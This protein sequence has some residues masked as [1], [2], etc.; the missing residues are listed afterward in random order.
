MVT[1][2]K[3]TIRTYVLWALLAASALQSVFATPA[4]VRVNPAVI[5]MDE[6][7]TLTISLDS[8]TLDSPDLSVLKDSFQVLKKTNASSLHSEKGVTLIRKNWVLTLL[9]KKKGS[10]IIPSIK[11]G[12]ESTAPIRLRVTDKIVSNP[13]D[14]TEV[15]ST[16]P[17]K[18]DGDDDTDNKGS[19]NGKNVFVEVETDIQ[20][21]DVKGYVQGQ[22]VLTQKIYH[23]I[24]LK[25]ATLSPPVIKNN[26]AE[27]IPLPQEA[28][29]YWRVKGK[30]YHVIERSY[31]LFPKYSGTLEIEKADFSGQAESPKEESNLAAFGLSTGSTKIYDVK[32]SA[33]MLSLDINAQAESYS[34]E[35]WLPAKNI[36]LYRNWS[37]SLDNL[38]I[39]QPVTV[40]LGIIADGLRA[41]QLPDIK[42]EIP[43]DVKAYFQPVELNN[44]LTLAGVTGVWSQKITLIPSKAKQIDIPQFQLS[45]WNTITEQQETG[46]LEEQTL[47]VGDSISNEKEE[48]GR[49]SD[50]KPKQR[51]EST[52]FGKILLLFLFLSLSGYLFY[53]FRIRKAPATQLSK[54]TK[55]NKEDEKQFLLDALKFACLENDPQKVHQLLPQWA[56]EIAGIKPSTL[57][58]IGKANQGYMQHEIEQ[59]SRALY[60]KSAPNW[61]GVGLW[62]VINKYSYSDVIQEKSVRLKKMYP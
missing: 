33:P 31:A 60:A 4:M 38:Q 7:V 56:K 20:Q 35:Y 12:N 3:S 28:P 44:T 14:K 6:T 54:E 39:G 27:I 30:R 9:P 17:R 23:M 11:I 10:L 26:A 29:Y 22:V 62:D 57:E 59:L 52:G 45:W 37:Q 5:A 40:Q 42:M 58:G 1:P 24:P 15:K 2:L 51:S 49:H 34:G 8:V 19:G 32:A 55:N 46:R 16:K 36:T 53:R 25:N 18:V 47:W 50:S 21:G 13:S 43:Q 48:E 41:E 61:K